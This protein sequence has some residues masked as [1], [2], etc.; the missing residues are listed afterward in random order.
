MQIRKATI[1]DYESLKEIKLLAKSEELKYSETLKPL[2]ETK[3]RYLS[4][5]RTDLQREKRAVFMAEIDGK[6]IGILLAKYFNPLLISK[7]S[8][9]GYISNVY[10]I[11]EYRRKGVAIKLINTAESWL[12]E[13]GVHHLTLEIHK[14]NTPAIMLCDQK[15]F[16][17]YTIKMSKE[18]EAAFL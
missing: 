11:E 8:K 12:K 10:I 4:Y 13:K 7:F 18:Y 1:K 2:D 15:G 9:K 3:E 6:I 16:N 14:D 17:N 5:L